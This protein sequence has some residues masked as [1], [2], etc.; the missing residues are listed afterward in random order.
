MYIEPHANNFT[1]QTFVRDYLKEKNFII[2]L[3]GEFDADYMTKAACID[4]QYA[5]MAR[6]SLTSPTKLDLP[7]EKLEEFEKV[8]GI[9][10]ESALEAKRVLGVTDAAE[11][12]DLSDTEL[13]AVWIDI[14]L[15]NP[16]KI[17]KLER[18]VYCCLVDNISDKEPI[19]SINGFFMGMRSEYTTPPASVHY[20]LV[21]WSSSMF[22]WSHYRSKIIG[23]CNPYEADEQSLRGLIAQQW[24]NL[25]QDHPLDAMHNAIHASSSAFESCTERS[26]WFKN[27]IEKDTM[28]GQKLISS[29]I[30]PHIL[31][32]WALN[33][34]IFDKCVFDYMMELDS[35]EC[36]AKAKVLLKRSNP[37]TVVLIVLVCVDFVVCC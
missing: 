13:S 9:T 28:F 32:E 19:F 3:E 37:G 29:G 20:F 4:K 11:L 30:P 31:K 14:S 7:E 5:D 27:P 24:L 10:W 21:E 16:S 15:K 17:L 18:S 6:T 1:T 33:P 34:R 25:R 36:I 8:F 12:L 2:T 35:A 22:D 23:S 26:I